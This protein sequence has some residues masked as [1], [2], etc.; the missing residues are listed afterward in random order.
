MP[1]ARRPVPLRVVSSGDAAEPAVPL[2]LEAAFK[3]YAPYVA[4]IALRLLGRDAEVDDVVQDVFLI[5]V[6]GLGSLRE[7][8]AIKGWLATVTVRVARKKLRMRRVKTWLRLDDAPDYGQVAAPGAS[9][10]ERALLARVYEVLDA[11]PADER[12]AWTLRN[13]EREQLDDV[14]RLCGCS[15][16]TV[17]RRISAAQAAIEEVV[18]S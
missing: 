15:L 5:A 4:Q 17:K 7:P 8:D 12:I 3:R 16:A 6:K 9:P 2:T 1:I 10:E 14:A 13:V 18:G 11:Q